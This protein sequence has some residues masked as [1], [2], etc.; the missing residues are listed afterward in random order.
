MLAA[1]VAA[2]AAINGE[3]IRLSKDKLLIY[4]SCFQ[5][6]LNFNYFEIYS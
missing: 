5:P 1:A 3:A 2:A 6:P 4:R